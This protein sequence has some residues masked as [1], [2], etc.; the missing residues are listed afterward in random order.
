[1]SNKGYNL[2]KQR[3]SYICRG[4]KARHN[5]VENGSKRIQ[6][7]VADF[8]KSSKLKQ[9]L[10]REK[11]LGNG[12]GFVVLVLIVFALVG[13]FTG[14]ENQ[15]TFTGLLRFLET[16]PEISMDWLNWAQYSLGDWGILNGLRDLL[17][18]LID[19]VNVVAFIGQSAFQLVLYVLWFLKFLFFGV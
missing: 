11:G 4:V 10:S 18:M 16:C 3:Q 15:L 17:M 1:M 5:A 14:K 9:N 13:I 12:L 2:E 7:R 19:T 8:K 6:F